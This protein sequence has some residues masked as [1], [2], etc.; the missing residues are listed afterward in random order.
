MYGFAS[1]FGR[2]Q[3]RRDIESKNRRHARSLY[4]RRAGVSTHVLSRVLFQKI[5]IGAERTSSAD[6]TASF[7]HLWWKDSQTPTP[8][9]TPVVDFLPSFLQRTCARSLFR[10]SRA[11]RII[12]TS[13]VVSDSRK[14]EEDNMAAS[15]LL[16]GSQELFIRMY[17]DPFGF[18]KAKIDQRFF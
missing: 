7:N 16:F 14:E 8:Y 1:P 11:R 13:F 3:S 5:E 10:S 12:D 15:S 18:R 17:C 2:N 9:I 6:I 4:N